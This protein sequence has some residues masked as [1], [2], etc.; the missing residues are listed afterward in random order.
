MTTERRRSSP[1]SGGWWSWPAGTPTPSGRRAAWSSP[2]RWH[3]RIG[4]WR[5]ARR[6]SQRSG[7]AGTSS[8]WTSSRTPPSRS[9][10]CSSGFSAGTRSW[11]W[12]TPG[13]RSTGGAAP[14]RTTSS[15]SRDR[16]AGPM[17]GPRASTDSRSRGATT[18]ASS[19]PRT[20]S[21]PACRPPTTPRDCSPAPA[22]GDGAVGVSLTHCALT[23]PDRADE[24]TQLQ[25]LVDWMLRVR[26]EL[27]ARHAERDAAAP[28]PTFA[29]LC[30]ARSGFGPIAAALQAEDLPVD[31]G[32]SRGLLDD[33]FVADALAV[34]E[35]LVD[36]DAGDVLMR[37]LSG[38]TIRL[39][40]ADL[41]AFAGFVRAC[42]VEVP[43]PDEEN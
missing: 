12:A 18:H 7:R 14:V 13:R 15:P 43:D 25:E 10:S 29:V 39:G 28:L 27:F 11:P 42:A 22:A 32:G 30:R 31:V 24:P 5:T 40:A 38:R 21:P 6:P 34:L 36:P 16:S 35:S 4:S 20:G 19:P 17:T 8:C 1:P 33:P 41:T 2:T 9:S 26:E 3:S 37:L 23:D